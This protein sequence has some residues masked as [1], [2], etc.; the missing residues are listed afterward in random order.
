MKLFR[1]FSLVP[2]A[3]A[4]AAIACGGGDG[5]GPTPPPPPPPPPPA[6]VDRVVV[7]PPAI[8]IE[9]GGQAAIVAFVIG[10]Q[11]DTLTTD[12]LVWESANSQVVS[13]TQ[14]G[15]I[16]AVSAGGPVAVSAT[17]EGKSASTQVT[18][19][20]PSVA[21]VV[22]SPDTLRLQRDSTRSFTV[23]LED[24]LGQQL[25][26]RAVTWTAINPIIV[27]VSQQGAV[28]GLNFGLTGVVAT[29]EGK[30]DT[31]WAVVQPPPEQIA[32]L[33]IRNRLAYSAEILI[34]GLT[35]AQVPPNGVLELAVP[36]DRPARLSW[37][38]IPPVDNLVTLGE[39]VNDSFPTIAVPSTGTEL[40]ITATLTDGRR[41]VDPVLRNT[42]TTAVIDFPLR[43]TAV[44][45]PCRAFG[46]TGLAYRNYGLWLLEPAST[47]VL[48][49]RGDDAKVGPSITVPIPIADVNPL[50]GVWEYT[51]TQDP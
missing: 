17:I 22:I 11:G 43:L 46:G 33:T 34:D 35:R 28:Q 51:I 50:T 1:G 29:S 30:A 31:A 8:T 12:Q 10:V 7:N 3:T 47:L 23:R 26:E 15:V 25:T 40:Q 42:V 19:T 13:V 48:Y 45:C 4:V 38:L 49:G 14:A 6:T 2:V 37:A 18:V 39:L 9:R 16:T 27:L 41:Y 20:P 32:L 21:R 36:N 24:G 44:Q 5:T